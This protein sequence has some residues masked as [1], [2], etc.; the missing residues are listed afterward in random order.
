MKALLQSRSESVWTLRHVLIGG[1]CTTMLLLGACGQS[2]DQPK[3]TG[4]V[5]ADKPGVGNLKAPG[6]SADQSHSANPSNP[7][8]AKP[9]L[10]VTVTTPHSANWSKTLAAN[11]SVAAW[12]EASVGAEVA[13]LRLT[14]VLVNVGDEVKKGQ[15]LARMS[16][17]TVQAD[18]TQQ[19]AALAEA[20]ATASEAHD[21]AERARALDKSGAISAQQVSQLITAEQTAKARAAAARARLRSDSIKLNHTRVVAPDD[22]IISARS[23]TV[24]AVSQPGQELF[25]LIRKGRLEW[26]AEVT[27]TELASIQPGQS[28]MLEGANGT[29]IEGKVR[30]IAPTVDANTRNALVYV[31]LPTG[32]GARAGMF[33]RG[34][35]TLGES[36]ALTLPASAVL[37]R[38]GF[39]YVFALETDSRVKLTKVS[40][41]RRA[42]DDIEIVDGLSKTTKVVASGAGFLSDGDLVRVE[43][44]SV[45]A[46][47]DDG[48]RP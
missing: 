18:L 16:D 39:A 47:A 48:K 33:A 37:R 29:K 32:S 10:T 40:V 26:R 42:G 12:Q 17:E 35:F 43:T 27:A 30:I 22:G 6:K 41:G 28:V 3:A 14:D 8:K 2:G 5:S 23:A 44:A 45:S 15:L 11:G 38:E 7:S 34:E 21:N 20:E 19:R 13:G 31:D 1:V 36:D 46:A 4:T 24:G 9:A 25:R